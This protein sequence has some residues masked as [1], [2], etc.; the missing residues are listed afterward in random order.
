MTVSTVIF[1]MD[2]TIFGNPAQAAISGHKC[3][4]PGMENTTQHLHH[5][6]SMEASESRRVAEEQAAAAAM[7]HHQE[8]SSALQFKRHVVRLEH[9]RF[10]RS[11]GFSSGHLCQ[12][13]AIVMMIVYAF[14]VEQDGQGSFCYMDGANIQQT[15]TLT[16]A[17]LERGNEP[18][19][20]QSCKRRL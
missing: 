20:E 19:I 8:S 16:L 12:P 10:S 2:G 4:R 15:L 17:A 5:A 11:M 1:M 3:R 9:I 18:S 7:D 6:R 14:G 13:R